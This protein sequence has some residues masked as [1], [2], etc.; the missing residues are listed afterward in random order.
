MNKMRFIL[1]LL[2]VSFL[3]HKPM[4]G[5]KVLSL[6]F[7]PYPSAA[8]SDQAKALKK[9]EKLAL[10][11]Y[12]AREAIKHISLAQ[13][14]SGIFSTYMGFLSV[15]DLIGQ[16]IF[17]LW[18]QNPLIYIVVTEKITPITMAYNTIDHWELEEG[19]PAQLYKIEKKFDDET[20]LYYWKASGMEA[21]ANKVV[22][23]D[24]ITIFA[25]PKYVYVPLGATLATNNSNFILPPMYIKKGIN[26]V[27]SALYVLN[28]NHF[29]GSSLRW[30][31]KNPLGYI[32]YVA[33]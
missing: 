15:S 9:I 27:K 13:R 22:P 14:V 16:T 2:S 31:K 21:P 24:S 20:N 11:G 17:P 29:F 19:T 8:Q 5:D 1:I 28:L 10:P 33:S 4:Y 3:L 30:L 12:M 18:Q 26:T 25:N 32:L 23:R 6:F 7:H